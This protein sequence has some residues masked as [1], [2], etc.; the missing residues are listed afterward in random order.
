[1]RQRC[2]PGA[3]GAGRALHTDRRTGAVLCCPRS[4]QGEV[5]RRIV[6]Q[7]LTLM[8]GLKSRSHV[9]VSGCRPASRN[10]TDSGQAAAT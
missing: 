4:L 3:S 5:E 7:L 8:D 6:S 10:R 9:I 1:M 2:K